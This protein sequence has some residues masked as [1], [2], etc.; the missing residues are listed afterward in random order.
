[1]Y[2]R[3]IESISVNV[4]TIELCQLFLLKFGDFLEVNCDQIFY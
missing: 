2:D 1:M 4:Y 3:E